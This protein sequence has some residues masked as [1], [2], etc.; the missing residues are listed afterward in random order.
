[1]ALR[2]SIGKFSSAWEF[3]LR[4]YDERALARLDP[5]ALV[6]DRCGLFHVPAQ[7]AGRTAEV[8]HFQAGI[9]EG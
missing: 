5:S 4:F 6:L 7:P 1:M 3:H 8:I 2:V 9:L